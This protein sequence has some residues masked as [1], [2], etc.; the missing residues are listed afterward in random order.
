[1]LRLPL[2]PLKQGVGVTLGHAWMEA[3]LAPQSHPGVAL[4]MATVQQ[5]PLLRT[6]LGQALP[7]PVQ[8]GLILRIWIGFR[9]G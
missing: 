4:Q 6:E 1:M 9:G 3:E 2:Q 7:Q 8:A 5:L